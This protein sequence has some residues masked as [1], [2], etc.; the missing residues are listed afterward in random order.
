MT[1]VGSI[2]TLIV[3]LSI[4]AYVNIDFSDITSRGHV[5][6]WA[7]IFGGLLFVLPM[8]WTLT[9]AYYTILFCVVEDLEIHNGTQERPYAMS[10]KLHEAVNHDGPPACFRSCVTCCGAIDTNNQRIE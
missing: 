1:F 4:F 2:L 8:F 10:Q 3:G 6:L 5:V 7:I 9:S